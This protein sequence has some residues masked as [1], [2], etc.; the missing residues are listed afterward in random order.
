MPWED[1]HK[2]LKVSDSEEMGYATIINELCLILSFLP[3]AQPS[4]PVRTKTS[5]L[6]E[7]VRYI[8]TF[9]VMCRGPFASMVQQSDPH[10]LLLL[11]H[12]Y[13][14]VRILLPPDEGWWAYK[15]AKLSETVLKAWLIA[16]IGKVSRESTRRYEVKT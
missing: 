11:Y 12:F 15:R 10:A 13:R 9:P 7:L 2:I 16:E 6:P 8:F 4:E 5:L 1:V 14:A 3:E